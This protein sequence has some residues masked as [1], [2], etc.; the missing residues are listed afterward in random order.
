MTKLDK[1]CEKRALFRMRTFLSACLAG[2]LGVFSSVSAAIADTAITFGV[3]TSDKPSAVVRKFM[4]SLKALEHEVSKILQEPVKIKIKVAKTYEGGVSDLVTGVVDFSRFG[5]ASYIAAKNE[6][7]DI[8]ILAMES[9][10]GKKVFHGVIAVSKNSPIKAVKE[11]KGKSFAFGNEASTIGRYLS[12]LYL[13]E[14]GIYASD[15]SNYEY[16]GRHDRVG[17][18]VDAGKFDAGALKEGTFN[19]L[20]KSGKALKVIAKFENVTKPWIARAG[21]PDR[22]RK[23]LSQALLGMTDNKAL[24]ALA[25]GGFLHG[26]DGDYER[27]R[28]SISRNGEFFR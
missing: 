1:N 12:Q 8:S 24:K 7:P 28:R 27:I 21:L 3:Y 5:P 14:H 17:A 10:K 9:K 26:T 11:L 2:G 25:K 18:D 16:L 4:P 20:V 13:V 23:A 22:I 15:L 6:N 19:S